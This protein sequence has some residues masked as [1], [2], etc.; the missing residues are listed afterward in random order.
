MG[1]WRGGLECWLGTVQLAYSVRSRPR[2]LFGCEDLGKFTNPHAPL[3][4]TSGH[5]QDVSQSSLP[6]NLHSQLHSP[7]FS[8]RHT[9]TFNCQNTVSTATYQPHT[10][11]QQHQDEVH[12][13]PQHPHCRPSRTRRRKYLPPIP[14]PSLSQ[15]SLTH[16][17]KTFLNRSFKLE[18]R[19]DGSMGSELV[20][21]IECPCTGVSFHS[22]RLL[23]GADQKD[24]ASMARASALRGAAAASTTIL[25][26]RR[27]RAGE[28]R[29]EIL[30]VG[31]GMADMVGWRLVR[32]A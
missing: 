25:R 17:S 5:C 10:T 27:C 31:T 1:S 19:D 28:A 30:L 8:A 11:L 16:P 4:Y 26:L 20:P 12:P 14:I 18:V 24:R 7:S 3:T 6:Y 22:R 23:N 2:S 29:E 32:R 15:L 13:P 9:K 21:C